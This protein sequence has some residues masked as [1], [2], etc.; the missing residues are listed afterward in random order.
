M[1]KP[2]NQLKQVSLVD[3]S[4]SETNPRKHIDE[5]SLNELAESIKQKG[6]L[7]PVLIRTLE[8]GYEL[9]CGERRYRAALVAGLKEIP[10]NIRSMNDDEAF[11]CQIVENLERKDVHPLEEAEAF[12]RM[13]DSGKY[14]LADI[15]AKLAKTETFVLQRLKLNDL[16]DEVKKDFYDGHLGVGHATLLAR[17]S[18]SGQKEIYEDAHDH[19]SEDVRYGTIKEIKNDIQG[20]TYD[21]TEAS[22]DLNSETL[23]PVSGPCARCPKCSAANLT[24]FPD[25]ANENICFDTSCFDLKVVNHTISLIKDLQE[26][27]EKFIVGKNRW[28]SDPDERILNFTGENE[29]KVLT[30][31]DDF[32]ISEDTKSIKGHVKCVM[33]SGTYQGAVKLAKLI[34]K[35]ESGQ[36]EDSQE[37]ISESKSQIVNIKLRAARQLE[38]DNEKVEAALRGLL[39]DESMQTDISSMGYLEQKTELQIACFCLYKL[40]DY[41]RRDEIREFIGIERDGDDYNGM[42]IYEKIKSCESNLLL[43]KIVRQLSIQQ[44]TD[45]VVSDRRKNAYSAAFYDLME[46]YARDRVIEVQ[47]NQDE[48]ARARSERVQKR[49]EKLQE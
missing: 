5:D 7:Q 12:K 39:E 37:N 14:T 9:I 11:E 29:I 42:Q 18:A 21:L 40:I 30:M 23:N 1:K 25:M 10:A 45:R 8:Q 15:A 32:N 16:I 17:L 22:F 24:L 46:L 3:I 31:Y 35:S 36:D 33:A 26:S 4:I 19:Y 13:I 47:S 43:H 27:G 44:L 2:V 38:L 6:V 28:G 48:I 20:H 41:H 34:K 49:I